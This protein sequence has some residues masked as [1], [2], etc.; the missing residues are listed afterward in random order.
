MIGITPQ[1]IDR[2]AMEIAVDMEI[3]AALSTTTRSKGDDI[4][5]RIAAFLEDHWPKASWLVR[6]AQDLEE[7][8]R[9]CAAEAR[10][11]DMRHA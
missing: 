1:D 9:D 8:H 11:E 2:L 5:K 10:A 4:S 3:H 6:E 7:Y